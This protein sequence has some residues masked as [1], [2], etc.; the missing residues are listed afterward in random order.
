MEISLLIFRC[1]FM[2][3]SQSTCEGLFFI[4]IIKLRTS[5]AVIFRF[6]II[7][8]FK[9]NI[10]LPL[11]IFNSKSSF[12]C[13]ALTEKIVGVLPKMK[14]PHRIEPHQIQGLDFIHIYPV[15]QVSKVSSTNVQLFNYS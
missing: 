8:L 11:F 1:T 4:V 5:E 15:V 9:E 6:P 10:L 7:T 12:F 13:R 14:C 2:I 3:S